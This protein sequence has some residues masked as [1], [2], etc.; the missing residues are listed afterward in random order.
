MHPVSPV[1]FDPTR[2]E[3]L[4]T[5]YV[6]GGPLERAF[7]TSAEVFSADLDRIWRRHWLYAGHACQIPKPGDWMT[8]TV[9]ADAIVLV[10]GKTGDV[11]AFHNTCRHRGSR[12]C[13]GESGHS[14]SLVCPYHAWTYELDGRLRTPTEREFGV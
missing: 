13:A 7:Y 5:R 9:G 10:R 1:G 8:W 4:R 11:G 14:R 12:I 6:P 2:I 3:T